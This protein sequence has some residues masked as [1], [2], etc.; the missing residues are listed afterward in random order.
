MKLRWL[1]SAP[2]RDQ[3][4]EISPVIFFG[5]HAKPTRAVI[6]VGQQIRV[7][8]SAVEMSICHPVMAWLLSGESMSSCIN[9]G[10]HAKM[11]REFRAVIDV[12][13]NIFIHL[14]ASKEN[15]AGSRSGNPHG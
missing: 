4:F 10:S 8:F 14:S 5:S 2:V 6:D 3:M 11:V 1:S 9:Q 13:A 15:P 7:D 12:L